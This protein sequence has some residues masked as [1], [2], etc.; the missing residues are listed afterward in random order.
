MFDVLRSTPVAALHRASLACASL[1]RRPPPFDDLV[2]ER[3]LFVGKNGLPR[4][5]NSCT[6]QNHQ[7][8]A[9]YY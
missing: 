6:S 9:C 8:G 7:I 4:G 2:L 5:F 3:L 1:V